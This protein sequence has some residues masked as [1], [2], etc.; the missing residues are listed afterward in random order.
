[1]EKILK[2]EPFSSFIQNGFWHVLAQN[3]LKKYKLNTSKVSITGYYRNDYNA[4]SCSKLYLDNCSFNDNN[5]FCKKN[6]LFFIPVKGELY[7]CNTLQDFQKLEKNKIFNETS[8]EIWSN[9][10]S[11]DPKELSKFLLVTYADLKSWKFHYFFAFPALVLDPPANYTTV[12]SVELLYTENQLEDIKFQHGQLEHPLFFLILIKD[13]KIKVE[14]L[15]NFND[16]QGTKVIFGFTDHCSRL[17][18]AGWVLRNFLVFLKKRWNLSNIKVLSLRID[19]KTRDFSQSR[20]FTI[21]LSN[22]INLDKCPKSVGW[23]KDIAGKI[24]PRI[25][26]LKS[27]MD[28]LQLA[29]SAVNLNLELMRWKQYPKLNL[30]KISSTKC[31]LLGAGTLGCNVSRMLLGW[32]IKHITFVDSGRVSYSNPVR[33]PLFKFQDCLNNGKFKAEC[34]A[35]AL[36]EIY[37]QVVSKGHNISIPMPGHPISQNECEKV[38]KDVDFLTNLFKEHDVIFLLTDTRESRWLPTLLGK[39]TKKLVINSALGFDTYLVMHH[40]F[41]FDKLGCY[42]CNDVVSP[43]DSISN[44]TLDQQ[45]TVTRPGL[46]YIAGACSVELLI[47]ILQESSTKNDQ[48]S[49]F[50]VIPHQIRGF[51]SQWKNYLMTA[52]A[53]NKCVACSDTVLIKYKM[54]GFPFLMQ[55]FSC[56]TYLEDI[57]G[58]TQLAIESDKCD[59]EWDSE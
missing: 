50:N 22:R 35:Q 7:N 47:S 29:E 23:E 26:N 25:I 42:F 46:A 55:V 49:S 37:P 45:C 38:K 8:N 13:Q 44:N 15:K 28:P 17:N 52:K 56:P 30:E 53:F 16:T 39:I 2:F 19:K 21:H 18:N 36:Y 6:P 57:T 11:D 1:M 24:I 14:S 41:N 27:V 31:L 33:Q 12:Q 34:A 43:K 59:I 54:E 32:G 58:L 48:Y 9:I 20:L 51:I 5:D 10:D 4:E 3:K 40:G